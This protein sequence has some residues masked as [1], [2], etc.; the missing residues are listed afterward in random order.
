MELDELKQEVDMDEHTITM[1]E[2]VNRLGTSLENVCILP[3]EFNKIILI[4]D[5]IR[6]YHIV[7]TAIS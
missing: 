3:L 5:I 7:Y 1:D 2:L 4:H 6:R